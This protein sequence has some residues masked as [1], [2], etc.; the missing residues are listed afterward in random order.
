M[1]I[2]ANYW[3]VLDSAKLQILASCRVYTWL[4][5]LITSTTK[6][7]QVKLQTFKQVALDG[8]ALTGF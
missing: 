2:A 7:L 6:K 1:S 4:V 5:T 3:L 8:A